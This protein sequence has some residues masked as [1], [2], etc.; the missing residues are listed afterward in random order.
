MSSTPLDSVAANAENEYRAR[1]ILA[2]RP[3]TLLLSLVGVA[4]FALSLYCVMA[5]NLVSATAIWFV[6]TTSLVPGLA[7]E[8]W[9]LRRRLEAS[10][11][12]LALTRDRL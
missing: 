2:A 3:P 11:V 4:S 12:L 5:S 1:E 6:A 8:F 7:V 10:L 9:F